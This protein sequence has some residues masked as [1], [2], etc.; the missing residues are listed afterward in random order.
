MTTIVDVITEARDHTKSFF[1]WGETGTGKTRTAIELC[2]LLGEDRPY[3]KKHSRY[4]NGYNHQQVVLIDDVHKE[5]AQY[6]QNLLLKWADR[7]IFEVRAHQTRKGNDD[8]EDIVHDD[9]MLTID[10]SKYTLIVCSA[11]SPETLFRWK[12]EHDSAKFERLFKVVHTT[13]GYIDE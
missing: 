9:D 1:L 12:D 13:K 10:P 7:N 11:Y 2:K 4:W 5:D 8:S 3:L 6:I